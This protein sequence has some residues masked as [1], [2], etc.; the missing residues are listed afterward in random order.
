MSEQLPVIALVGRPN[1]GKS[2][3]FNRLAGK[4]LSIVDDQPGVTR[5]YK[6]APIMIN[7]KDAVLMDTAGLSESSAVLEKAMTAQSLRALQQADVLVFMIDARAGVVP[8]DNE[9]A[10]VLRKVNKPIILVA[11][12]SDNKDNHEILNDTGRFGFGSPIM[13]SA[14]HGRG[15]DELLTLIEQKIKWPEIAAEE[16]DDDLQIDID[17]SDDDDAEEVEEE[18][19]SLRLAIVGRPNAG[20]STLLN[21]L[22]GEQRALVSDVAGTTRDPV[23][24]EWEYGDRQLRIVDTA[25]LRR[26]SRV[27]EKVEKMSTDETLRIIRLAEL[28]IM[29]IDATTPFDQQDLTIIQHVFDEGRAMVLVVNKWDKIVDKKEAEEHI[30]YILERSLPFV[31][32][33]PIITMSAIKGGRALDALLKAVIAQ[34]K[35]WNKRISTGPLNRWLD[36]ML[37]RNPPPLA[38]GRPNRIRYMTQT[39]ARPPTFALWLSQPNDLP[40][41][42]ERF[43]IGG[44]RNDFKMPGIPI[45]L[46]KKKGENPFAGK[47][48][49]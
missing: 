26:R 4:K 42:Y 6:T 49:N 12:K 29:V 31:R 16:I 10:S 28:V 13:L 46:I 15:V 1:V 40:D 11:N 3:L 2:S 8:S 37:A 41:T 35:I 25:G 18:A 33:I 45:R 5:D 24:V 19:K 43:L 36:M 21:A 9:F 44:M 47:A 7:N 27:V 20:K 39:K 38:K 34:H 32:G 22:I 17:V 14:A 23:S 48:A 30:E